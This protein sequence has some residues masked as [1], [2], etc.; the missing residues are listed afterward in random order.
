M[1]QDSGQTG[2][3]DD[4]MPPEVEA[5]LADVIALESQDFFYVSA[6]QPLVEI[7]VP[8]IAASV[9]FRFRERLRR[10]KEG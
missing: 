1:E 3:T 4:P 10:N 5:L 6:V 2:V 9:L 7:Q 8:S